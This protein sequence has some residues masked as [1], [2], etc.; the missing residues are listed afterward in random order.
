MKI[1]ATIIIYNPEE[2]VLSN[3]YSYLDQVDILY[4]IDNSDITNNQ[5]INKIKENNKVKYISN[6]GNKG[7][8]KALNVAAETAILDGYQILMTMDQ[9]STPSKQ[10]ISKITEFIEKNDINNIG[11]ISPLHVIKSTTHLPEKEVEELDMIMT[12]GN[13]LNLD[14]FIK[15]G[16]F[17][18]E[19]FIDHVDHEYCLRLR[20]N[21]YKI[22]RLNN[23]ILEHKL[24][25]L[26]DVRFL[27]KRTQLNYHNPIRNYY[28]Y[29][30]GFYVSNKYPEFP[31]FRKYIINNLKEHIIFSVLFYD[32][33]LIR[34]KMLL[35]AFMDYKRNKL[36]KIDL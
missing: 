1:A 33:K 32:N 11:I 7:I 29:R 14:I 19:L 4:I 25:N 22:I 30:N 12:S 5:L 36:G 26:K 31:K 16:P 2:Q 17:L 15:N 28:F 13:F 34:I 18:E 6:N 10:M 20:K 23:A 3:V 24:G 27:H 35:K 8:A 21:G 9:D